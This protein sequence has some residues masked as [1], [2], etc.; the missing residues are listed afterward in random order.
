MVDTLI[1][2]HDKDYLRETG[3]KL[4]GEKLELSW[5]FNEEKENTMQ[6]IQVSRI[7]VKGSIT[8]NRRMS[9]IIDNL[10]KPRGIRKPSRL[11]DS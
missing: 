8:I 1:A 7:I 9:L 11:E 4:V 3:K 5:F 10:D 2:H 6:G